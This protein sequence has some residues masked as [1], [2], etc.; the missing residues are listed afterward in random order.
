MGGEWVCVCARVRAARWRVC[1][2]AREN[3]CATKRARPCPR[4]HTN[5]RVCA[6]EHVTTRRW[7]AGECE[8]VLAHTD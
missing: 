7:C 6:Y 8:R 4:A 3:V 1:A 5:M 2:G